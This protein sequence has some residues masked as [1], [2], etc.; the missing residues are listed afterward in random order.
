MTSRRTVI[1]GMLTISMATAAV[2]AAP[3]SQVSFTIRTDTDGTWTARFDAWLDDAADDGYAFGEDV[4]FI[5]PPGQGVAIVS[6]PSGAPALFL[7]ARSDAGTSKWWGGD[8]AAADQSLTLARYGYDPGEP[9]VATTIIWDLVNSGDWAYVLHD[10]DNGQQM[11]LSWADGYTVDVPDGG[12]TLRLQAYPSP[13]SDFDDDGDVDLSDYGTFLDCYNGPGK[14]PA[15]SGCETPDFDD[16][17]DVDL[18]DYAAFLDCYN[19]PGKPPA[20]L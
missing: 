17:G 8:E 20:C 13:P 1:A 12:V 6:Q 5:A 11:I 9:A 16:D 10:D 7:D 2:T 18:G 4:A 3:V 19:G 14:P 15:S